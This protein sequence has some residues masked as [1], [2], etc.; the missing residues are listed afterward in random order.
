MDHIKSNR[1]TEQVKANETEC[2]ALAKRFD[3]V[4]VNSLSGDLTIHVEGGL[5]YH[6]TGIM[7]ANITQESAVSGKSVDKNIS[8]DIDAWYI[9]PSKV[10]S[11]EDAVRDRQG[12]DME[13]EREMQSEE[14]DPEKLYDGAIDLGEVTSQFLG[15]ALDFFPRGEDE[16]EGSGDYIEVTPEEAKPNPFAE[17]AKLK[18]KK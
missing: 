3:L 1:H 16:A 14:D 2:E 11:F 8:H 9:D 15:L 7:K 6:V 17:L 18:E 5:R 10:A 12:G 4:S 13:D